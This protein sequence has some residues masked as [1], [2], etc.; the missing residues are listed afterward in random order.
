M[1]R[2]RPVGE[3]AQ[4]HVRAPA[5]DRSAVLAPPRRARLGTVRAPHPLA[6][7]LPRERQRLSA[8][9][10]AARLRRCRHRLRDW[11]AICG[12]RLDRDRPTRQTIWPGERAVE[13]GREVPIN[14]RRLD[15]E[16]FVRDDVLRRR[17]IEAM[18]AMRSS[19]EPSAA[20]THVAGAA[21]HRQPVFGG[22]EPTT[23]GRSSPDPRKGAHDASPPRTDPREGAFLPRGPRRPR[24]LDRRVVRVRARPDRARSHPRRRE[25]RPRH[26]RNLCGPREP[27][28]RSQLRD[29]GT[30]DYG[31]DALN[32]ELVLAMLDDAYDMDGT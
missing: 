31:V 26:R 19:G 15:F 21:I 13:S 9:R 4:G 5:V 25:S 6:E 12:T 11:V 17:R 30:R 20:P 28:R 18:A 10:V 22:H 27:V 2:P 14:D 3:L 1:A 32:L 8:D 23:V 7:L 29:R 24:G 16:E